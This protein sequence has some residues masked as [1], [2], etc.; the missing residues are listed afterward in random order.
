MKTREITIEIFHSGAWVTTANVD[1]NA[2]GTTVP[3]HTNSASSYTIDYALTHLENDTPAT[4]LSC[5]YPVNF[6]RYDHPGWPPFLLDLLPSGAAHNIWL[7]R[8]QIPDQEDSACWQLLT[9]AAGNPAG[10][11]R[12]AVKQSEAQQSKTPR[13]SARGFER[14]EIISNGEDFITYAERCGGYV[15]DALG[16]QGKSPKLFMVQDHQGN[17]HGDGALTDEQTSKHWLVKFP[18]RQ[19]PDEQKILRNEA[20]YYA[21]ARAFGLRTAAE[22]LEYQDNV[23]FIPRFDRQ[24][25]ANG[26][27]RLG[28]ESLASICGCNNFTDHITHNQACRAIQRYTTNPYQEILEY[29][30][31][32]I[33]NVAVRNT[34]NHSR[35]TA[36]LKQ[37]NG[38]VALA[39]LFDF[40]PMFLDSLALTRAS[41]WGGNAEKMVELP[42]WGQVAE[43]L[44]Q[45]L[46]L[47]AK[48]LRHW[49]ATL[50]QKTERLPE[51]MH[52]CQVDSDIIDKLISRIKATTRVLRDAQP[53]H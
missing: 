13:Y 38:S 39:P 15:A 12:I 7:Q 42:N 3:F 32:D 2:E 33:L 53:H 9:S 25:N 23:L 5:R 10:N 36:L 26:V 40:A 4:R 1:F 44:Q 20:A 28:L 46:G 37:P 18:R 43:D 21:T 31:R 22:A 52:A 29:I 8:L 19:Q 24:V 50:A 17:W 47:P 48:D 6:Q 11:L 30:S 49:L 41:R 51:T 27:Q 16:V 35:N 14:Q 45:Q 34:D